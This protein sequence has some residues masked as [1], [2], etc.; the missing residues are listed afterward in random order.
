MK[1]IPLFAGVLAI[2]SLLFLAVSNTSANE[3]NEGC[4]D[5]GRSDIQCD[6]YASPCE[7]DV[8]FTA[9]QGSTVFGKCQN[10]SQAPA[11]MKCEMHPD[12]GPSGCDQSVVEGDKRKC[13]CNNYNAF[14]EKSVSIRI[15][16]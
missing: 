14:K 2:A 9:R 6:C 5:L 16:C 10:Q 15:V 11:Q 7:F 13:R 3:R 1:R 8:Q 4:H 12:T